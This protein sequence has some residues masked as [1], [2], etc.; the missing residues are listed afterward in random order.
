MVELIFCSFLCLFFSVMM[1]AGWMTTNVYLGDESVRIY[2][3]VLLAMIVV[4][5]VLHCISLYRR[6]FVDEKRKS[7][8]EKIEL[9][10]ENTQRLLLTIAVT[11]AYI[12]LL[13][14]LGFIILTPMISI[15]YM[16]ALG[17]RKWG[18]LIPISLLLTVV[19]YSVFVY[20]LQ[21][22][23]PRGTGLFREF[24]MLMEFLFR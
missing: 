15:W 7:F 20:A 2:P 14:V 3:S 19:V 11:I 4:C 9:S 1:I 5:L 13:D 17:E 18:K 8:L 16:Y 10:R 23:L 24:S 6:L 22:R 21:I 12:Y